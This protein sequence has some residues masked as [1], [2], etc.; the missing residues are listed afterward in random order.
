V[1]WTGLVVALLLG[2][3]LVVGWH[4]AKGQGPA[5]QYG[6]V[7]G[8]VSIRN[9]PEYL[10]GTVPSQFTGSF[11]FFQRRYNCTGR[12]VEVRR[13][14]LGVYDVRFPGLHRR[15]VVASAVSQEGVS[16]SAQPFGKDTYRVAL[17]GPIV[18]ENVL[19]RRDVAFTIAIF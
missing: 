17:R 7:Q 11:R 9:D 3:G 19:V 16:V 15:S 1:K 12:R 2:M 18:R 10:I 14:D 13:V 6:R 5:C 4:E 8:F